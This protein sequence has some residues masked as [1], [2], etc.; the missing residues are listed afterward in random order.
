MGSESRMPLGRTSTQRPTSTQL[1]TQLPAQLPTRL[2]APPGAVVWWRKSKKTP[3]NG[4]TPI[5]ETLSRSFV[6]RGAKSLFHASAGHLQCI[7]RAS[8]LH[9][10]GISM[11]RVVNR[12]YLISLSMCHRFK[13]FVFKRCCC[14]VGVSFYDHCFLHSNRNFYI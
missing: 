2:S 14:I 13:S 7:C 9:L 12:N 3:E 11:A 4:V 10:Q 5:A 1:P 8:P 6:K